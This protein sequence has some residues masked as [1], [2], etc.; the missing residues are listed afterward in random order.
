MYDYHNDHANNDN[1]AIAGDVPGTNITAAFPPFNNGPSSDPIPNSIHEQPPDPMASGIGYTIFKGAK[2][3]DHHGSQDIHKEPG[4]F[5]NHQDQS[6][7]DSKD[8]HAES[9]T[10]DGTHSCTNVQVAND[11]RNE[12]LHTDHDGVH[13]VAE[14]SNDGNVGDIDYSDRNA[15]N[16][17]NTAQIDYAKHNNA[18]KQEHKDSGVYDFHEETDSDSTTSMHFGGN[19]VWENAGKAFDDME[20]AMNELDQ[21]PR[22]RDVAVEQYQAV[23]ELV[24]GRTGGVGAIEKP[25]LICNP[26]VSHCFHPHGPR[27]TASIAPREITNGTTAP[28]F[29]PDVEGFVVIGIVALGFGAVVLMA[30]AIQKCFARRAVGHIV[31]STEKE[32]EGLEA[33]MVGT[34]SDSA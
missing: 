32:R 19:N 30:V 4:D 3:G 15:E 28:S 5:S 25:V 24:A 27:G 13:D 12:S 23:Q 9:E 14:T 34:Y 18:E 21:A 11:D 8:W 33:M 7:Q 20:K 6:D 2:S 31:L 10:P 26:G 22:K 17:N 29:G 1:E 16:G